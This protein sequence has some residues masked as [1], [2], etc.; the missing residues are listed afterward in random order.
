MKQGF[1]MDKLDFGAWVAAKGRG[2]E[3]RNQVLGRGCS[4]KRGSSGKSR[5]EIEV[6]W[7]GCTFLNRQWE[8][9]LPGREVVSSSHSLLPVLVQAS[10]AC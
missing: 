2:C 4:G 7:V 3:M 8:W 9:V 1:L 10:Q 6:R 5:H